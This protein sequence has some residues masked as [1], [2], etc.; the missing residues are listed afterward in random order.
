MKG[1][2]SWANFLCIVFVKKQKKN[3]EGG[4]VTNELHDLLLINDALAASLAQGG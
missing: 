4:P 3:K 1:F 2:A